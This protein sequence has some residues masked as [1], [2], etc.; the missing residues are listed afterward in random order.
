M[1]QQWTR[2]ILLRPEGGLYE[3]KVV[4]ENLDA[5]GPYDGPL[6]LARFRCIRRGTVGQ[7]IWQRAVKQRTLLESDAL[8]P[9]RMLGPRLPAQRPQP[10]SQSNIRGSDHVYLRWQG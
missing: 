1:P 5:H 2:G 7:H 4:V 6:R 3:N 8:W 9:I 10:S